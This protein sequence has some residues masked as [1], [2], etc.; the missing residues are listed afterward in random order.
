[1][2][3]G[4]ARRRWKPV[5]QSR[6]GLE[7]EPGERPQRDGVEFDEPPIF[8]L[9]YSRLPSAAI[10]AAVQPCNRTRC[11]LDSVQDVRSIADLSVAQPALE[12]PQCLAKTL[13]MVKMRPPAEVAVRGRDH[14]VSMGRAGTRNDVRRKRAVKINLLTLPADDGVGESPFRE[15]PGSVLLREQRDL[16][17]DDGRRSAANAPIVGNPVDHH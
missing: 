5:S 12:V 15:C 16:A 7:V 9:Q 11:L 8:G 6:I 14:R 2:R 17:P 13:H 4:L 10:L 3:G 1:M